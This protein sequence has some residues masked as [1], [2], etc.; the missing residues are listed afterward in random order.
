MSPSQE[1]Q[2]MEIARNAIRE[3][4]QVR[5]SLGDFLEGLALIAEQI[6]EREAAG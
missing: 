6:Q 2:F 4:E 1:K 3:A 5:C